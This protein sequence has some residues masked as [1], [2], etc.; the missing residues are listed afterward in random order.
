[1]VIGE[2]E[3]G[4]IV[5]VVFDFGAFGHGETDAGEDAQHLL[6]HQ[7]ERVASAQRVGYGGQG[8]VEIG[9][10]RGV[11]G[12]G[13]EVGLLLVEAGLGQLLKGVKLLPDGA[14][15]V[16]R[17]GFELLKQVGN[18][19]VLAP[20]VFDAEGV[21]LRGGT[22]VVSAYIGRDGGNGFL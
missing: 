8:V 10:G 3:G 22:Q 6:A 9:V 15:L 17:H 12:G 7:R 1:V 5:P 4:E 20:Q 16:V 18:D 14:L 11:V 21:K 13:F 19:A 2:V